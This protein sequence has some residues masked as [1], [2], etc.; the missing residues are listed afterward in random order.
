K[1]LSRRLL[2]NKS[3]NDDHERLILSKLKQQ[4]GGQFTF[5]ME[6]MIAYMSRRT[7]ASTVPIVQGVYVYPL[8]S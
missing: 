8:H 7:K 2:F 5:K 1:K 3:A 4:C 6:G